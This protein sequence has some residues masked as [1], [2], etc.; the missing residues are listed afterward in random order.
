MTDNKNTI[1]AI[2]LSAIVLIAWQYFFGM[3]QI[4]KQRQQQ[5]QQQ[6]QTQ[7]QGAPPQQPGQPTQPATTPTAGRRP[8]RRRCPASRHGAARPAADARGA[9]SPPAPRVADRDAA[10]Q[11]LDRPQGRAD[12]RPL[13]HPV[14]RDG[15]SEI[16]AD[17][18]AVAVRQPASVLRRVRLG[19]R[20]RARPPSCPAPRRCGGS[21]APA[22]SA[23]DR[24]VT[25]DLRQRRRARVPPHHRG[26]RQLPVHRPGR[27]AEQERVAGHAL[28]LRR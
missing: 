1:L 4:E 27:G 23:V 17:R 12:R 6:Q 15:R 9:C 25:L 20:P 18:P 24:P 26:R 10:D 11:G 7:Q 8:A 13:A 2:V 21:R 14:P 22:R 3:P 28:S 19:R 5:Q 16:A